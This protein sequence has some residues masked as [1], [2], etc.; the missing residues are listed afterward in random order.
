MTRITHCK[1]CGLRL[2]GKACETGYASL[3]D[4][5]GE[6]QGWLVGQ[7]GHTMICCDCYDE[8]CGMPVT[9]RS[10]PRPLPKE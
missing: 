4:A 2:R 8:V 6:F 10:H 7:S 3:Y 9:Y 5:D 1:D